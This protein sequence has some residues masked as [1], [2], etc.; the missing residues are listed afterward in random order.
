MEG[1]QYPESRTLWG[2]DKNNIGKSIQPGKVR[3]TKESKGIKGKMVGQAC[4][5]GRQR[6]SERK[7][8]K[9]LKR[10]SGGSFVQALPQF[11]L[12][13]RLENRLTR[14]LWLWPESEDGPGLVDAWWS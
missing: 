2:I 14:K 4:G 10:G 13:Q 1:T 12:V 6:R 7:M 3:C 11:F 8:R 5:D 9:D